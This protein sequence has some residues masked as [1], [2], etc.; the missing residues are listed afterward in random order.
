MSEEL[1]ISKLASSDCHIHPDYSIDALGTAEE[2][3]LRAIEMGLEKICFTTHIDLNPHRAASDFFWKINGHWIRPDAEAI[4]HYLM[5]IETIRKKYTD[6]IEII[7]GFEFSYE[8][9]FAHIVEEFIG[10]YRPQFAIGSVHSVDTLEITS[11]YFTPAAI[12]TFSP[13]EFIHKYYEIVVAIARSELFS[14]IGH[15]DGYKKYL[16]RFW[17]LSLCEQIEGEIIDDVAKKLADAG[18]AIEVNTSAWRKGL[19]APYPDACIIKSLSSAGVEI[20]TIG[21]DAHSPE[22]VGYR[23][24]NAAS[25]IASAIA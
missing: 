15:I 25:Y 8:P 20:A 9:H 10:N 16:P 14:V 6:R 18:A 1:K 11:R 19:P 4:N 7:A 24:E 12:R 5:N 2:F 21:S 17:G 3:A 13:Q 22:D 23:I